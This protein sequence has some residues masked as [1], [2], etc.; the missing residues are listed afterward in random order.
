MV[1]SVLSSL[2]TYFMCSIKIPVDILN[3]VDRYMRYCLWAGGDVNA[4][5]P[6]LVAWKL[7]TRP[8]SKGGLGVIRLR[9]QNDVLLMK[10][11]HKFFNRADLSCI[12]DK[13]DMDQ[14]LP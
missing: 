13:V 10:K 8:K 5:K 4:K 7:V 9:L 6:P 1:N 14:V 3:Q 2:P 11:L 12:M